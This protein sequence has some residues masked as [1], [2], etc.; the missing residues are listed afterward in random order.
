MLLCFEI[1][2]VILVLISLYEYIKS[3]IIDIAFIGVLARSQHS[4]ACLLVLLLVK[5]TVWIAA[6]AVFFGLL[7]L[8]TQNW[9]K[10]SLRQTFLV[11]FIILIV[12]LFLLRKPYARWVARSS[13]VGDK[14]K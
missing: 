8:E 1:S 12:P 4:R 10:A 2:A 14:S 11:L 5:L 7:T 6:S 13:Y 9:A 3:M